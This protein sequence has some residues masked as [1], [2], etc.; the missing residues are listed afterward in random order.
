M[1][2][3]LDMCITSCLSGNP[4]DDI[5]RLL[6]NPIVQHSTILTNFSLIVFS[7]R[8]AAHINSYKCF[9]IELSRGYDYSAFHDDIK[10]LYDF[11]GIQNEHTVFLFTDTQVHEYTAS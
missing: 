1:K 2:S 6:F 8:L 9:Q 4:L 3:V 11:A 7:F 5:K 10:K